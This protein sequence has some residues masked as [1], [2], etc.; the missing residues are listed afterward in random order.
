MIA[1]NC[2]NDGQ[3]GGYCHTEGLCPN[4]MCPMTNVS[5]KAGLLD[6]TGQLLPLSKAAPTHVC[7]S[8]Q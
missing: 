3:T 1:P 8:W 2:D 7:M 4:N 6:L 5:C